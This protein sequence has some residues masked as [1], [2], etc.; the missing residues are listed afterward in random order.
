M[1]GW[2][3]CCRG[4]GLLHTLVM[5]LK[6]MS[7]VIG[8]IGL[9]LA[10]QFLYGLMRVI[11]NISEKNIP[12]RLLLLAVI[13]RLVVLFLTSSAYFVCICVGCVVV[14]LLIIHSPCLSWGSSAVFSI[15]MFFR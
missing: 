6:A 9:L 3:S 10:K 5:G 12:L 2:M 15:A 7:T 11:S 8:K 14:V 13:W 1:V 4:F